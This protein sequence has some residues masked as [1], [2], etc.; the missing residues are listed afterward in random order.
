[1]SEEI[2][3]RLSAEYLAKGGTCLVLGAADTG[4]TTLITALAKELAGQSRVAIVDADTGQSHIGPPTTVGWA[5]VDEPQDD[6]SKLPVQAIS[7]VGDVAPVGHLL[8]LTSAIVLCV[9]AASKAAD[10]ILID[11]PG[12][13]SGSAAAALWW[14]VHR[15]IQ[16]EAIV[17][18]QR[19]NE[20]TEI[21]N[22][23]PTS[24]THIEVVS[25]SSQ[26]RT[27]S[28][29]ERR[30]YRQ[31]KFRQYFSDARIYN[32]DLREI[33][34]QQE[35]CGSAAATGRLVGLR[36]GRGVDLAVGIVTDWRRGDNTVQVRAPAID[37]AQVRCIVIGNC[38]IDPAAED[39]EY[40]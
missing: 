28:P 9:K 33:G 17:A 10:V 29:E 26:V 14:E 15:L 37:I 6:F 27:K 39:M 13:V 25:C 1:M 18:V 8:Q 32:I 35:S 22:G 12:F 31:A 3:E 7:F 19:E 24:H 38:S 4:K 21:L 40:A 30:R 23:L 36:D 20:L 11:T 2:A 5:I 34:V 16:P